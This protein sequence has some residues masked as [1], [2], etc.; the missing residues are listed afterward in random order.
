MKNGRCRLHGGKSTGP[1]TPE[2]KKKA[3]QANQ[4]HGE[5]SQQS[6]ILKALMKAVLKVGGKSISTAYRKEP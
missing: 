1:K 5:Y 3:A 2:G 4:K 6:L